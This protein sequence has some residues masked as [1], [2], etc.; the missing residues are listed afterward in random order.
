MWCPRPGVILDCIDSLL[1]L[2]GIISAGRFPLL[3][4]VIILNRIVYI[5]SCLLIHFNVVLTLVC[6]TISDLYRLAVFGMYILA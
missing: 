4:M 1:T 3:K 2:P 6:K 5:K